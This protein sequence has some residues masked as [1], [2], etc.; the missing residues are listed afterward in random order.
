M[1]KTIICS[2]RITLICAAAAVLGMVA[3]APL[4]RAETV[5]SATEASP[6]IYRV[7]AEDENY[8]VIEVTWQPGQRDGWHSHPP[9]TTYR[10]TTCE[11]RAFL[12][13]G[14]VR[15]VTR[16]AGSG[17]ARSKPVKKHSIQNRGSEVCRVIITE[18]KQRQ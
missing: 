3:L 18:I 12:A 17:A 4:A 9:S 16:E 11:L 15:E 1:A 5:P 14:T 6:D 2:H 8:R 7:V 10:V 13:D